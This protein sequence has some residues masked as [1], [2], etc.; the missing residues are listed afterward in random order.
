LVAAAAFFG[1]ATPS[2]A[3]QSIGG[4]EIVINEVRGNLTSG[5]AV[6]VIRGDSVF[7]DEVVRTNTESKARLV[8]LDNTNVTVGSSSTVK[9]DRFVYAGPERPGAI[10]LN[11]AKGAFRFVTGDAKKQAYSIITPTASIGVRGTILKIA[12]SASKTIV[13]LLE[14]AAVVCNRPPAKRRC[15][16]LTWP[17]QEAVVTV[18]QVAVGEGPSND[19]GLTGLDTIG[20]VVGAPSNSGGAVGGRG[21]ASGT[22]GGSTSAGG[23]SGTSA[24]G[25]SA[26]GTG[27]TGVG[28]TSAG[29]TSGTSAG[30]SSAGGTGGTG[31]TGVGGTSGTS[32]TGGGS[33]SGGGAVGGR[34][35][36]SGT[37][38][39]GTSAG[40][41][42][43][44]SAGGTSAGG[45]GGTGGGSTSGGG[46]VGGRGGASGTGVGGTSGGNGGGT[47]GGGKGGPGEGGGG[48]GGGTSGHGRGGGSDGGGTSAGESGNGNGQ[49]SGTGHAQGNSGH[50]QGNGR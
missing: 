12:S 18:T 48:V 33:T 10:T 36:A 16:E 11:L 14:G 24:G 3:E 45:T 23:T 7:R 28:G 37:G 25:T 1:G 46:A 40:G 43:G 27:G 20:S 5:S 15:V 13:D 30:G 49:G 6:L 42:G 2:R 44:T 21:G 17:N 47:S 19:P 4:A 34:G 38:V 31:G 29:G 35:G 39:G 32:G 50:G 26:G 41:T 9:L 22:G 8:L